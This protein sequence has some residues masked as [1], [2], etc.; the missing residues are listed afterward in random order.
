MCKECYFK[1]TRLVEYC[2][3]LA[4][5]STE[6]SSMQLWNPTFNVSNGVSRLSHRMYYSK[7]SSDHLLKPLAIQVGFQGFELDHLRVKFVQAFCQRTKTISRFFIQT[8]FSN[9]PTSQLFVFTKDLGTDS[10]LSLKF[11]P[12]PHVNIKAATKQHKNTKYT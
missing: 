6:E 12:C 8:L 9:K 10:L 11:L 2:G 1:H 5:L 3:R 4:M 7:S